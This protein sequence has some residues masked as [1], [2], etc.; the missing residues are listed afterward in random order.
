MVD[1]P[2]ARPAVVAI[3]G[4]R[5]DA[6]ELVD[7][8]AVGRAEGEVDVLRRIALGDR[9]GARGP[10]EADA[11]LEL[12]RHPEPGRRRDRLVE[13]LCGCEIADAEPQVI[14]DARPLRD[15]AV[16]DGLHAVA[17]R[18]EDEGAVVVLP[19]LRARPR[20][21]VVAIPRAGERVP[22]PVDVLARGRDEPDVQAPGHR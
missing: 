20:R 19:V 2:L 6:V 13:A 16:V 12:G 7:G 15:E 11:V 21:A 8:G 9:E 22:E 17:V 18:V 5:R 3:A 10:A 1:G 14:Y 4:L